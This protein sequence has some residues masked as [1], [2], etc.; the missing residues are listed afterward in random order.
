MDAV[1]T[2][3]YTQWPR[4]EDISESHALH[5]KLWEESAPVKWRV[6]T[7]WFVALDERRG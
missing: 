7:H 1:V 3:V 5:G 4:V 2:Y 6:R